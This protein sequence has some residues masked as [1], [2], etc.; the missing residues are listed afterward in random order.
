MAMTLQEAIDKATAPPPPPGI[1]VVIRISMHD[2]DGTVLEGDATGDS[3]MFLPDLPLLNFRMGALVAPGP[4]TVTR[5]GG[6]FSKGP[7]PGFSTRAG[8]GDAS[9]RVITGAA[10]G[11]SIPIDFSVRKDPGIIP[12]A[13][14]R[15][16]G[17]SV[18]IEIETLSAPA[19]GGTAT[20]GIK[21]D[22]VEENGTLLRAVG[23]SLPD[24]AKR[25][26]YTATIFVVTQPG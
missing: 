21:L 5:S 19:P 11:T 13:S 3:K 26:S 12:W 17:P 18:Q 15:G 1:E 10:P 22:P 4:T 2:E 25:A 8:R 9:M 14:F 7:A 16:L 20:A 24:P 6:L 23:P